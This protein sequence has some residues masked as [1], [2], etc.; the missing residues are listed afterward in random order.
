MKYLC[1]LMMREMVCSDGGGWLMLVV[2][3]VSV[4]IE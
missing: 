2:D 3:D 1:S 4:V